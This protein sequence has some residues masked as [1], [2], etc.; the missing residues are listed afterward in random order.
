MTVTL[1]HVTRTVDGVPHIRDVSL[2][3]ESGTLN[4]LLGPTLSGKTS[5]MRLLAGLDK[6]TSGKILVNGKDVTG[7]D[8]RKRSVA[9]VYQQFINYPSLT[10]YENIASPLRVQGKPR[11]EI[12]A[13]VAEAARL[14]RL[15]PFLKRT[16]LQ[17]SGGQQQRTAIAR[18]LVKGADL[19]L[20][21][22]PLANLDYKLREELR[23]EL[24]RIFEAS[25]AIFVYATTEPT[26]AL[27]LGGQHGVH[28][29]G[30]GAPDRRDRQRLPPAADFARRPGILRPAA[31]S[32]RHREEERLCAIC[33]RR[34]VAGLGSVFVAGGRRLPGRLSRASARAR[35]RPG[36]SPRLP[37]HGNGD[38]NHRFGEFRASDPRRIE[39]GCGVAR[40][41][42]VR[43][44]PDHRRRARSQ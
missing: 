41:A 20:L 3:L 19:V 36:R 13:R 10:V 39:M 38:R 18:A 24:P 27:L 22:E 2:T 1:D 23:A 8:V 33:R 35:Q 15:E 44:R 9:M 7:A 6:P 12:E 4:V 17:L 37:C 30:T 11:A 14:L 40:R 32:R 26:E 28:V 25:G 21:D 16:P 43:A 42:R 29:A 5:I 31:Q 34:G